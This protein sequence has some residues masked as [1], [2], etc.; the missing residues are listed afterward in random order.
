MTRHDYGGIVV[1]LLI[2][3]SQARAACGAQIAPQPPAQNLGGI[4][5]S[6]FLPGEPE[7]AEADLLRKAFPKTKPRQ[8]IAE[9]INKA[10]SKNHRASQI[11]SRGRL[12]LLL[13][14][15]L[16][17][18]CPD[19]LF[20]I[21][22]YPQWPLAFSLPEPL[23]NNNIFIVEKKGTLIHVKDSEGL[24]RVLKE[25]ITATNEEE[26]ARAL[27]A[28]LRLSEELHQDGMYQFGE[29]RMIKKQ[30]NDHGITISGAVAPKQQMGNT[31][32][33]QAELSFSNHGR[34]LSVEDV[35]TLKAG[36]RPICQSTL[37]LD[38][39]PLVRRIAERD[40]LIMGK[41]CAPYLQEQSAKAT[42]ALKAEI[43]RIW[44]QI[45]AEDR[46]NDDRQTSK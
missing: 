11:L 39:N 22:R 43:A 36:M 5:T 46:Y 32:E 19:H 30:Q 34:L 4:E 8:R 28:W 44:R 29:P 33:I 42:P 1:A 27:F 9:Y 45:I 26:A 3:A 41:A 12:T 24:A 40:L 2:L 25:M 20:Y 6:G 13:D 37:L 14:K 7:G 21:V 10:A 17:A 35:C 16:E 15:D 31:G 18:S 38:P 23:G